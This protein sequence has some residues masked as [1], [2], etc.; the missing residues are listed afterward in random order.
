[1]AYLS[2]NAYL[3]NAYLRMP[4]FSSYPIDID[5]ER[6]SCNEQFIQSQKANIT[7]DASAAQRIM[8]Q[9]CPKRMKWIGSSIK[10]DQRVW[11]GQLKGILMK[12]NWAKFAQHADPLNYLLS[13]GN[14]IIGEAKAKGPA[15]IGMHLHH[16]QVLNKNLWTNDN[17]MGK[18]L[19]NIREQKK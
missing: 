2:T 10:V 12:C 11:A 16:P 15:G 5:G 9:S 7:G 4:I 3:F 19:M 6:Y 18:C 1:M 14:K 8:Q 13:T 17:L